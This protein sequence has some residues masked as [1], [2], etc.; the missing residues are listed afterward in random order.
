MARVVQTVPAVTTVA[1]STSIEL[2]ENRKASAAVVATGTI[3]FNLEVSVDGTNFVPLS[4]GHTTSL[5]LDIGR[6]WQ[7]VRI[8]VTAVTGGNAVLTTLSESL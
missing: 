1:A 3:T 4:T 2:G 5:V 8:D 6:P 7:E